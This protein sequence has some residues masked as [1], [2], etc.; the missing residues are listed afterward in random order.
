MPHEQHHGHHRSG[1]DS[2][3]DDDRQVTAEAESRGQGGSPTAPDH[4]DH[5]RHAE[6]GA[7]GDAEDE[8]IRQGVAEQR[9]HGQSRD[10][11]RRPRQAG[12]DGAGQP[13]GTDDQ[14]GDGP[15][16]LPRQHRPDLLEGDLG[17]AE[18]QARGH[19]RG[20]RANEDR[21]PEW[22]PHQAGSCS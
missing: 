7:G 1:A 11:E 16:G 10:P 12:R 17:G 5:R 15:S 13:D 18:H 21:E 14:L 4:E 6:R 3:C 20:Q 8:R 9:L 2:G 22:V 19:R